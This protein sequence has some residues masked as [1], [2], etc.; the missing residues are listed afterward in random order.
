MGDLGRF[1]NDQIARAL[2]GVTG[3]GRPVF[4]KIVYHGPEAMEQLVTYDPNLVVGILGGSSGTTYDAFHQ[5]CEARQHGANAALYGRMI[6]NAE[7]Q[8]TFIQHLRWLADGELDDPAEA[9][10][11][12]HGELQ[13]LGIQP[14][15]KLEDDLAATR[16]ASS[17]GGTSKTVVTKPAATT[18]GSEAA[19]ADRTAPAGPSG[20]PD[21]S[22]MSPREKVRWNLARWDRVL[23]STGASR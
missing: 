22:T 5:L 6:N 8:T 23:G 14:Y 18:P 1:I 4:L 15:R 2:A 11:S 20:D 3:K 19:A 12:Y 21:F 17:Y 13:K 7:H 16:R 9:V 10:R